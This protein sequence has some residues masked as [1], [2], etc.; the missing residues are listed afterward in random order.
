MTKYNVGDRIVVL[1]GVG[2]N[3]YHGTIMFIQHKG[4]RWFPDDP[5]N[6]AVANCDY[7]YFQPDF[8]FSI[9][10]KEHSIMGLERNINDTDYDESMQMA[11]EFMSRFKRIE[12][13]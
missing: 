2:L 7:Y 12:R 6:T 8:D 3:K 9:W 13:E 11:K 10:V 4:E 1:Y 5:N